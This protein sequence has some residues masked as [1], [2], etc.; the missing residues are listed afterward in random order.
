MLGTPT[1]Q[2]LYVMQAG[3]SSFFKIGVAKDPKNRM[4]E[5]QTGCP[6]PLNL[7][8]VFVLSPAEGEVLRVEAELLSRLRPFATGGGHEWLK[9]HEG[10]IM[11][12][13]MGLQVRHQI[14]TAFYRDEG[15]PL[16]GPLRSPED[17][18]QKVYV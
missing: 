6:L 11:A 15:D 1:W 10:T 18:L 14:R 4:K 9:C 5:L 8:A 17:E 2:F 12:T 7:V 3:N 16:D 13:L